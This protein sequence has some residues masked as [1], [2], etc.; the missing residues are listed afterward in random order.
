MLKLAKLAKNA[1]V[2]KIDIMPDVLKY[3][4]NGRARLSNNAANSNGRAFFANRPRIHQEV[5]AIIPRSVV[6]RYRAACQ[7]ITIGVFSRR[8]R[9]KFRISGEIQD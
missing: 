3:F 8:Y 2:A 5:P 9:Y 4:A 7:R 6:V 1:P